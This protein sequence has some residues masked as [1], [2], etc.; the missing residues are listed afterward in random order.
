MSKILMVS[1]SPFGTT[2]FGKVSYNLS[3][4]FTEL[5]HQVFLMAHGWYGK[6]ITTKYFTI[7][8]AGIP[9]GNQFG[10]NTFDHWIDSIKPDIF[11]S[12]N[13]LQYV[14]YIPDKIPSKIP[15]IAYYPTDTDSWDDKW[16]ELAKKVDYLVPYSK[17]GYDMMMKHDI[18]PYDMIYH[19]VNPNIYHHIDKKTAR[20]LFPN[21]DNN[22]FIIGTVASL[23]KRKMWNVWFEVVDRFLK[24]K[25]DAFSVVLVDPRVLS[26]TAYDFNQTRIAKGLDKKVITPPDYNYHA[27]GYTDAEINLYY[28]LFDCHLLTTGGE[29]FGLPIL[30]SMST[31]CTNIAT[32]YSACPEVIGH[33]GFLIPV[34]KFVTYR[35]S[36][37]PIADVDEGVEILNMLYNNKKMCEKM[38]EKALARSRT[39]TWER[40]IPQWKKLLEDVSY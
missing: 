16:F 33:S 15:W 29:G 1:D 2:G 23:N 10:F 14:E 25:D 28:N 12:V 24:D 36:R 31:G 34:R 13:D 9:H 6:P 37:R 5:G 19:G 3:K 35:G 38:G 7:L 27:A 18:K 26:A 39:M 30:E 22:D 11:I 4:I 20:D 21:I 8:Q 17:F 32:D 40:T